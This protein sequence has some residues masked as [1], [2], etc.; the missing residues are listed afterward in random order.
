MAAN[1]HLYEQIE[2]DVME[3]L[4][5][6]NYTLTDRQVRNLVSYAY[7]ILN[8]VSSDI[9]FYD[10]VVRGVVNSYVLGTEQF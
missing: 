3:R 1:D 6:M 7:N 9:I 8:Y 5:G 10:M 4:C 2:R